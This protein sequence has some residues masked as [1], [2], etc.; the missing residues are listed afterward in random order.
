MA[1]SVWHMA[2]G[3]WQSA[4]CRVRLRTVSLPQLFGAR[5]APYEL[6]GMRNKSRAVG[7]HSRLFRTPHSPFVIP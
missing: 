4:V 7:I 1:Y 6:C 3:I 2:Y 5:S